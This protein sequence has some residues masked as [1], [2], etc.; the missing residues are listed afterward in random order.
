MFYKIVLGVILTPLVLK[1][2]LKEMKSASIIFSL[3]VAFFMF[4]ITFNMLFYE[5]IPA[6]EGQPV[7][8]FNRHLWLPEGKTGIIEGLANMFIAFGF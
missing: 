8:I 7:S 1:K 6:E 2:E 4:V 5:W 3:G